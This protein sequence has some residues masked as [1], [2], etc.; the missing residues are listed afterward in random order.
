MNYHIDLAQEGGERTAVIL[1]RW[2]LTS[3]EYPTTGT[4][5]Q[6]PYGPSDERPVVE[7]IDTGSNERLEYAVEEALSTIQ[8]R[9]YLREHHPITLRQHQRNE[10][11]H[12]KKLASLWGAP[13]SGVQKQIEQISRQLQ[14]GKLHLAAACIPL[15]DKFRKAVAKMRRSQRRIEVEEELRKDT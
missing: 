9:E 11:N 3:H 6:W 12:I 15:G 14:E 2:T 4:D 13:G 8:C 1:W 10:I 7:I 5:Q